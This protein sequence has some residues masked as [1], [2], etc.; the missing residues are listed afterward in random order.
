MKIENGGLLCFSYSVD[1]DEGLD[2][3][4]AKALLAS[5]PNAKLVSKKGEPKYLLKDRNNDTANYSILQLGQ[6]KIT[7]SNYCERTNSQDKTLALLRFLAILAYLKDL[8]N[9]R[10]GS[11]YRE[12][13]E[14]LAT[15]VL[16]NKN[17][18]ALTLSDMENRRIDVLSNS[19]IVLSG[20]LRRMNAINID[21]KSQNYTY[22]SFCK[23]VLDKLSKNNQ[24]FNNIATALKNLGVSDDSTK[25]ILLLLSKNTK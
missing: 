18:T 11:L 1:I 24:N 10:V 4:R 9:P 20:Q 13:S 5:L 6:K 22:K 7:L 21:I 14:A 23:E 19:N 16:I 8:C 12:I 3:A 17:D 15:S 25:N 2:I